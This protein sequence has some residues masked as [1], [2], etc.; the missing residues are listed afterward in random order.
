MNKKI[1]KILN[2]RSYRLKGYDY[3]KNGAY[4]IT[5][6]T[7]NRVPYFGEIVNKEMILNELGKIA[8]QL[9][10]EI[11]NQFP[12]AKLENFV[13]MPDHIHGII[14]IDKID[15][16]DI[17]GDVINHIRPNNGGFAGESNPMNKENI[18]RIIRW[19]KGRC[20]FELRKKCIEFEWQSLYHDILI[21]DEKAF[22]NI[23]RYIENNPKN[24]IRVK[25]EES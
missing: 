12:F 9:W 24:Y 15:E 20:S 13:V 11:P 25:P 22:Q 17:G 18:P 8:H 21:R 7:K 14:L 6:C 2:R 3:G 4:F 16:K 19:F 23:Q 10:L 1:T 5:F